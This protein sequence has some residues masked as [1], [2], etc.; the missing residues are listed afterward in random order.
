MLYIAF[1]SD[2]QRDA[3]TYTGVEC[4]SPKSKRI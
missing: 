4:H 2:K 1:E 3:T